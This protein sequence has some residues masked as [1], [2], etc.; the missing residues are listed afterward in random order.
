[1]V[2]TVTHLRHYAGIDRHTDI[3]PGPQRQ[4]SAFG[5]VARAVMALDAVSTVELTKSSVLVPIG[6]RIR[7]VQ[8]HRDGARLGHRLLQRPRSTSGRLKHFTQRIHF[9][10]VTS[11][12]WR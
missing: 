7:P 2:G 5:T 6:G 9:V 12:E 1:M 4:Q 11:A 3:L 8:R 10:I